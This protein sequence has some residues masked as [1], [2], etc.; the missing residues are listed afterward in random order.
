MI[1]VNGVPLAQASSDSLVTESLDDVRY[2]VMLNP[3][4]PAEDFEITVPAGY[5]FLVGDNRDGSDD[6]R[7]FGAVPAELL[8]GEVVYVLVRKRA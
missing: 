2:Q 8:V 4:K 7:R 3:D 5:Y 6:S 1:S